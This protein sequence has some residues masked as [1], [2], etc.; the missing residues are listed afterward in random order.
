MADLDVCYWKY[1]NELNQSL[2]F[3]NSINKYIDK[4]K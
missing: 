2:N 4:L 1:L 3:L